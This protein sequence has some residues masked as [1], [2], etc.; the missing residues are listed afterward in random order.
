MIMYTVTV[1]F[2]LLLLSFE[3]F[4]ILDYHSCN[5]M[6][7]SFIGYF[8][9]LIFIMYITIHFVFVK[10]S[11]R[12]KYSKHISQNLNPFYFISFEFQLPVDSLE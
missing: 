8:K 1:Y 3:D 5:N 11:I 9:T 6:S 2:L 4:K 10:K 12:S 7:L